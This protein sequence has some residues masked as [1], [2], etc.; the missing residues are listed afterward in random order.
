[1]HYRNGREAKNGDH[2]SAIACTSM[3]SPR[4]S[5]KRDSTSG[6]RGNER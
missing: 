3:I 1:M 6:R 5:P 4:S 2:V